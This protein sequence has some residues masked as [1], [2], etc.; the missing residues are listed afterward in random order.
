MD[1]LFYA[2]SVN[3]SEVAGPA[4]RL[5]AP[6]RDVRPRGNQSLCGFRVFCF[7]LCCSNFVFRM[8]DCTCFNTFSFLSALGLLHIIR[9]YFF[10]FLRFRLSVLAKRL[11]VNNVPE[12]TR[13][14]SSGT[15][16]LYSINQS[17]CGCVARYSK[18]FERCVLII[19]LSR[20]SVS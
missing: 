2:G 11:A 14:V 15:P 6:G 10:R 13:F 9:D 3:W 16:D 1:W 4:G 18:A 20:P 19:R 17:L 12:T 8:S 5:M 7:V